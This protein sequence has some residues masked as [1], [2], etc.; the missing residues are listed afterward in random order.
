MNI[1]AADHKPIIQ[2]L[3]TRLGA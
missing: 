1:R 2:D 3:E